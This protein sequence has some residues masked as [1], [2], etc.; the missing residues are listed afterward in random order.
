MCDIFLDVQEDYEG[1]GGGGGQS[2][3]PK[4]SQADS[5]TTQ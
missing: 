4:L 5:Y 2:L 3:R 1:K